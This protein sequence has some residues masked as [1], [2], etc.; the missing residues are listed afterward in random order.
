MDLF[1][2]GQTADISGSAS[3]FLAHDTFEPAVNP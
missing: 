3:T 1:L 2:N